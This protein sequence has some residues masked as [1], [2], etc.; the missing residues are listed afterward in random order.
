MT[1]N[2]AGWCAG[3]NVFP[4]LMNAGM[5]L[6]IVGVGL[7]GLTGCTLLCRVLVTIVLSVC[8][9]CH[10]TFV[11]FAATCYGVLFVRKCGL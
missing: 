2:A 6:S 7:P 5:Q 8:W 10:F 1:C 9:C 4:S 3:K 11:C